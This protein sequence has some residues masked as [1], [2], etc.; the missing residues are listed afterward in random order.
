MFPQ[1]R[2][3]CLKPRFGG[4]PHN[5]NMLMGSNT[6]L[7]HKTVLTTGVQV[8]GHYIWCYTTSNTTLPCYTVL[9]HWYTILHHNTVLTTAQRYHTTSLDNNT[10]RYNTTTKSYYTK[11]C[12][13]Y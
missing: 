9:Q 11:N 13:H 7:H 3:G 12:I 6:I 2:P 8:L 10:T 1:S 4:R 5:N